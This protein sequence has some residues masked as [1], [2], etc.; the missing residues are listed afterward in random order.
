MKKIFKILFWAIIFNASAIAVQAQNNLSCYMLDENGNSINLGHLCQNSNSS[1]NRNSYRNTY[2]QPRP[3]KKA[4]VHTIPIKDRRSG[5]PVIDVKFNNKYT[6]EMMLDTGASDIVI[7]QQMARKLKVNH[8]ETVWVSTP[9]SN[10]FPM[11]AGYVYSVGVG[12][13][14][15]KNNHVITSLSM[16]MGLLGQS[17]FG[18]YDITIKQDVVEFRER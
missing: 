2:E 6:F 17:F 11:L 10:S 9:S 5:I 4:G 14:T 7:T 18:R 1:N 15:Q 16:D 3:K 12:K 13:L 8:T